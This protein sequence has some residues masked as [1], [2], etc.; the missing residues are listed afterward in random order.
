ML[1][2]VK[3]P[4]NRPA[5]SVGPPHASE[6]DCGRFPLNGISIYYLYDR[7]S[8]IGIRFH[9]DNTGTQN[10]Y[11]LECH[12]FHILW[13]DIMYYTLLKRSHASHRTDCM[14][15]HLGTRGIRSHL[16]PDPI[17]SWNTC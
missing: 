5:P 15:H 10:V 14:A 2:I 3:P 12:Q 6:H 16:H 13:R 1:K 17:V 9:H 7:E 4:V 11:I 8:L